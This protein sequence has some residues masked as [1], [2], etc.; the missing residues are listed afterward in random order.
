MSQVAKSARE[1]AMAFTAMLKA[2]D[3]MGAATAFNAPTIISLEAMDGPMA[4]VEGAAA[5]KAKSVWWFDNHTVHSV[6]AD[7]PFVNGDQFA[8]RFSMD[9]TMKATGKRTTGDE[10]GIY[11]V[12]DGKIV[13]ERFY[14]GVG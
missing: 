8:V 1:V 11:T 14:Y 2:N 7:G 12:K 6:T 5:V 10:I 13:E 9:V 4:R 3:H